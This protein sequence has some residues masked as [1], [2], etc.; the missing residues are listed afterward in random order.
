MAIFNSYVSLPEGS[1]FFWMAWWIKFV[2]VSC[3][4]TQQAANL[5]ERQR[6]GANWD[7]HLGALGRLWNGSK[8]MTMTFIDF[9]INLAGM[10][11]RNCQIFCESKRLPGFWPM[12]IWISG[13][14]E[15]KWMMWYFYPKSTRPGSVGSPVEALQVE[16]VTAWIIGL[17]REDHDSPGRHDSRDLPSISPK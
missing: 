11:I 17:S 2:A 1:R 7:K 14:C 15:C 5:S 10:N 13:R 9:Y 16:W 6:P 12:A 4:Q 8:P 3:P